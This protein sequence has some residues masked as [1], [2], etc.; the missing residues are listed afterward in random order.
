VL[1]KYE[2][3]QKQFFETNAYYVDSTFFQVFSYD[4]KFGDITTA[5]DGPNTIVI[6]DAVAAKLFANENPIGKVLEVGLSNGEFNYT[7]KGVFKESG[8]KSHIP[9]NLFLSMN[10]QDVGTWVDS[11]TSWA[12]NNIFHTYVKLT[13]GTNPKLFESKLSDFL[14]RNGGEEFKAAGFEKELFI[15][16]VED[17]YLHSNYGYEVASNGNIKYLYIFS[18]IAAFILSIACINFM[19]LS[20]ARSEKRA[21]EVGMRKAIG[22]AKNSLV[23]QF[24]GESLMMCGLALIF[25][26][27]MI[28]LLLPVFNQLT[29]KHLSIVNSPVMLIFLIVFPLLTGIIAGIYPAFYLSSFKP[30]SILKGKAKNGLSVVNIRKGLV[31]FQFIISTLL[32]L[33]AIFINRQLTY[34]SNLSLGFDKDQKIVLPIQTIEANANTNFLRNKL[35]ESSQ[36]IT[37]AKGVTYPGIESVTRMLFRAEGKTANEN[38]E[39]R[40]IYASPGTWKLWTLNS[41]QVEDSLRNLSMMKIP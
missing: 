32:I 41:W 24:M 39:I 15:Q 16:P 38:V 37:T 31:V 30:V 3:N 28:Q 18:S 13:Q 21:K 12:S 1:L 27:I 9:A 33:G 6:S 11:Q 19:N 34:M 23:A 7:I 35:L 22:A 10:N 17:I 40:T 8:N 4:F 36:I 20:T 5:L 14:E 26:V 25:T 29:N 2:Q